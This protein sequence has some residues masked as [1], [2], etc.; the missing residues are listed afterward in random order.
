[1]ATPIAV[2]PDSVVVE[3]NGGTSPI[4]LENASPH[5]RYCYKVKSTNNEHYRVSSVYGFIEP[6]GSVKIDVN[7]LPGPPK[8]DDRLEIL[9]QPVEASQTDP[10]GPFANGAS[11]F[12][13]DV[14]LCAE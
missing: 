13:L 12:K 2:D 10:K 9:F 1:M 11:E 4:V 14:K 6:L 3:A 8:S 7:R 5:N